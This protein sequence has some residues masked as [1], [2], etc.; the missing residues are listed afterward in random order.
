MD[1]IKYDCKIRYIISYIELHLKRLY[2]EEW[3]KAY[4][5]ENI[6]E[7][8]IQK[9]NRVLT[10]FTISPNNVEHYYKNLKYIAEDIT[11]LINNNIRMCN[12][13]GKECTYGG[14][15][16]NCKLYDIPEEELEDMRKDNG[17]R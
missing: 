16:F 17:K 4:I 7:V 12:I 3:F 11:T 5:E 2:L 9:A 8:R 13:L 1:K 6:C 15:C 14:T 10:I